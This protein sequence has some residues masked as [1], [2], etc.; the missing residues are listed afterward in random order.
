LGRV[1]RFGSFDASLLLR[2]VVEGVFTPLDVVVL[3]ARAMEE[4]FM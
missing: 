3:F 2:F 4:V 1:A